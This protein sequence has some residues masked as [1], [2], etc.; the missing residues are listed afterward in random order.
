[1]SSFIVVY[2]FITISAVLQGQNTLVLLKNMKF[3]SHR[4]FSTVQKTN[5]EFETQIQEVD[6]IKIQ[7]LVTVFLCKCFIRKKEV[8]I[9]GY[10][11]KRCKEQYSLSF[12][13]LE[14]VEAFFFF[15]QQYD[16]LTYPYSAIL[17]NF[18][19]HL[20]YIPSHIQR[21]EVEQVEKKMMRVM[22][23][24]D[25][26]V[27]NITRLEGPQKQNLEKSFHSMQYRIKIP[28]KLKNY[29]YPVSK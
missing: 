16:S 14:V 18:L 7:R 11:G 15:F 12:F 19:S 10:V 23:R 3:S 24:E 27:F 13:L 8:N 25:S 21:T 2:I 26:S 6:D 29:Y 17:L 22:L 9:G 20:L 5:H 4:S 1:M 28:R